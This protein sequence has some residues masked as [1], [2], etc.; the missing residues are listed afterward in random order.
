MQTI[1]DLWIIRNV[2]F[3]I[4][5]LFIIGCKIAIK[6]DEWKLFY[7]LKKQLEYLWDEIWKKIA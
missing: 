7:R 2:L 6:I 5:L 1:I 4:I 3:I